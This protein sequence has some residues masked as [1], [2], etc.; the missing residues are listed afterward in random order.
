MIFSL[1]L[2]N[3][4]KQIGQLIDFNVIKQTVLFFAKLEKDNS[5]PSTSVIKLGNSF[6]EATRIA[7]LIMN[8][9]E[10]EIRNLKC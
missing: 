10:I 7:L 8:D 9:N 4:A 5:L 2:F 6:S 3:C 1:N